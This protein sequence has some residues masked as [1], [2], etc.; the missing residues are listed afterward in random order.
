MQSIE[1]ILSKLKDKDPNLFVSDPALLFAR[2]YTIWSSQFLSFK[3]MN[4]SSVNKSQGIQSG[5]NNQDESVSKLLATRLGLDISDSKNPNDL[6]VNDSSVLGHVRGYASIFNVKDMAKDIILPGSFKKTIKERVE[7][8]RV[9]L[10]IKHMSEGSTLLHTIGYVV[11]NELTFE[12][13]FGLWMDSVLIDTPLT[14][15]VIP[16]IESSLKS[17]YPLGLSVEF[18]PV[19]HAKN[20]FGGMTFSEVKLIQITVTPLPCNELCLIHEL[21]LNLDTN[22]DTG[23]SLD[24]IISEDDK[25]IK[26][27]INQEKLPKQEYENKGHSPLPESTLESEKTVLAL[28]IESL[29]EESMSL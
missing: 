1:D 27:E 17:G 18:S 15:K 25:S 5:I 26:L 19:I 13:E 9:P 7:A 20:E 11:G 23:I 10:Q 8:K 16:I 14:H 22:T 12:D 24:E 4:K 6:S 2:A 29:I 21:S 28:L 3:S